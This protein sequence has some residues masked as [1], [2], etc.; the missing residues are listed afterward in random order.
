MSANKSIKLKISAL[1][2]ALLFGIVILSSL[3]FIAYE[4]GHDCDGAEC[5]VCEILQQCER[6][7]T[8]FGA[9]LCTCISH[10][11]F[12]LAFAAVL[13]CGSV[14]EM[15]NTLISLKVELLN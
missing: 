15:I 4:S 13:M 3:S 10:P 14:F 5:S 2:V 12:I 8:G 9:A 11:A 1:A 7:L 6:L